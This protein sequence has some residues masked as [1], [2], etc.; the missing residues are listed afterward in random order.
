MKLPRLTK[1]FTVDIYLKSGAVQRKEF[2]EF[3]WKYTGDEGITSLKWKT[4]DGSSWSVRLDSIDSI[5]VISHRTR[6]RLR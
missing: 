2:L 4:A 5:N 3:S 1:I 6:I